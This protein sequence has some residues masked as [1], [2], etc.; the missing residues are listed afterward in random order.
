[1]RRSF[2][3]AGIQ[4]IGLAEGPT[5]QRR[6]SFFGRF[7]QVRVGDKLDRTA[8]S[9]RLVRFFI[10]KSMKCNL[11]RDSMAPRTSALG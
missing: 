6:S 9:A 8:K 1:M 3:F 5:G 11:P 10:Y 2:L 7:E 4:D